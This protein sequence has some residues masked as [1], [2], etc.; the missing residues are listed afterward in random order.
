VSG[1]PILY[2]DQ[3]KPF[4]AEL[5]W[6]DQYDPGI[7]IKKPQAYIIPQRWLNVVDNLKRNGVTLEKLEKDS[8][9]QVTVYHI[10]GFKTNEKAFEKHNF[11]SD[12]RIRKSK[13]Q[14][15]FKKGDYLLP[16]NQE[17]NRFVTE[18]L[19]P[20]GENSFFAWNYFDSIV[21]KTLL[22]PGNDEFAQPRDLTNPIFEDMA[23]NYLKENPDLKTK[24]DALKKKDKAFSQDGSAQL[25]WVYT[26]SPWYDEKINRYPIYRIEK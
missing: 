25:F 4:T 12:V 11:H 1:Q 16:M 20:E 7:S 23:A 19:E 14:I 9:L 3:N 13:E 18:V 21:D 2:Y 17:S 8:M 26:H 5:K 24:L 15:N 10:K 6:Y 22:G